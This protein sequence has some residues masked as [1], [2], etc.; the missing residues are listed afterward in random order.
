MIDHW[1]WFAHDLL[2]WAMLGILGAIVVDG[3]LRDRKLSRG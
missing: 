2:T 3:F 1:L